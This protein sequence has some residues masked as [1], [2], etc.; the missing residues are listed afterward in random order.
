M[1]YPFVIEGFGMEPSSELIASGAYKAGDKVYPYELFI[2]SAVIASLVFV[3]AFICRRSE[4]KFRNEK[5]KEMELE[6]A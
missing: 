1:I 3:P 5:L 6:N 2:F 4:G